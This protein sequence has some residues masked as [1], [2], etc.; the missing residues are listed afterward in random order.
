MAKYYCPECECEMELLYEE[1]KVICPECG[2]WEE[3]SDAEVEDF[4]G[5]SSMTYCKICEH[6]LEYPSCQWKCPYTDD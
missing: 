6:S 2:C 1:N 5:I 4:D 3:I